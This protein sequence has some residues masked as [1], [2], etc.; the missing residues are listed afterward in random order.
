MSTSMSF[1]GTDLSAYGLHVLDT[2]LHPVMAPPRLRQAVV[3][4]RP[5]A[6]DFDSEYEQRAFVVDVVIIGTSVTDLQSKLDSLAAILDV[7]LGEQA[8]AFDIHSG[9]YW[10]AKLQ[11]APDFS[12]KGFTAETQL[13]FVC[14]DPFAYSTTET[15]SDHTVD[16]DPETVY[17]TP[18]GN[19]YIEPV[20]TLTAGSAIGATTVT[21]ANGTTA[22]TFEWTGTIG[23][24]EVLVIDS[25]Q[26]Y[27]TLE[28]VASMGDISGAFPRL[29]GGVK[30]T[31]TIEGF[32]G[33]VNITYRA[34]YL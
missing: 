5:G 4:G 3:V 26:F 33:N 27:V 30:N 23:D 12:Y 6:Y 31:L 21:I 8:L 22:E 1:G 32:D 16:E 14:P 25:A 9:R 18:G 13:R 20:W 19:Y 29:K 7:E 11:A 28:G 2:T 24:G 17:E 15:D 34:R 10:L